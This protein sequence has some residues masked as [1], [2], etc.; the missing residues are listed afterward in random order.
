[1]SDEKSPDELMAFTLNQFEL[2]RRNFKSHYFLKDCNPNFGGQEVQVP[3]NSFSLAIHNFVTANKV[4]PEEVAIR[5][6]ICYN[7]KNN[8]LYL[9]MQILPMAPVEGEPFMFKLIE[10]PCAWY[11]LSNSTIVPTTNTD[12]FDAEY[13]N[14]FYYCAADQCSTDTAQNLAEDK[15]A[16]LYARTIV[17]PWQIEFYKLY[18]ENESP[19]NATL[20]LDAGSLQ[21]LDSK[22]EYQHSIIGYLR[23]EDGT[24]LLDNGAYKMAFVKKAANLGTSCPPNCNL[25]ILPNTKLSGRYRC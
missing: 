4:N 19:S 6:V 21:S 18:V 13:L 23:A 14:Y 10:S 22:I 25:Y 20:C 15:D 1:M 2:Q 3:W 5:F 24:P 11:E 9:R 8:V 16:V 12:L 17:M 7:P